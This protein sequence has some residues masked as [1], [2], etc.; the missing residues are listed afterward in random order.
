[1]AS[2]ITNETMVQ[3]KIDDYLD[4]S[5]LPI[6]RLLD[7]PSLVLD[8]I[9]A[10]D[11]KDNNVHNNDNKRCSTHLSVIRPT[12][13]QNSLAILGRRFNYLIPTV[14]IGSEFLDV[15]YHAS[16]TGFTSTRALTSQTER[17]VFRK[18]LR[19]YSVTCDELL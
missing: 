10:I 6:F 14:P 2:S 8:R 7:I 13:S 12:R 16:E 19:K 9:I 5:S 1:M 17:F 4:V 15:R 11:N 3:V 18:L